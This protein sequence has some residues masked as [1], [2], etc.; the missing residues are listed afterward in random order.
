MSFPPAMESVLQLRSTAA[1]GAVHDQQ[2][3]ATPA[4][5]IRCGASILVLGRAI[6]AA[7]DPAE[8]AQAIAEE[9]AQAL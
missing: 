2:R 8:A 9:V 7:P 3:V 1:G 5:A 4:D 6:T